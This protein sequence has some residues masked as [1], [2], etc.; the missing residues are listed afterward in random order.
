M[1]RGVLLAAAGAVL[2]AGTVFAW[3]AVRQEREFRRLI[4]AGD[5]ALVRDQTFEAIE[6]FSGALA[7]KRDSM[8]GHLKRGDSYRRRGELGAA[9]RDLRDASSLDPTATRPLEL[10][11]DVN[12]AMGRYER[13]AEAYRQYVALDDRAPRLLYK[14]ALA[15]YRN[16]RSA[17]AIESLRRAVALD[18]RF[19]EAHYLLALC[20]RDR[21]LVAD[22]AQS[23]TRALEINPAFGAAREE[24]AD[25][26]LAQGRTREGIEQ[27]EALAAL[28][29]AR[30]QRMVNVGLAYARSG[31]T[32]AAITTLG[33]AAER[34][35]EADAVYIALGRVWLD[36]AA[37]HDD[38]VALS[39]SL[40]ALQPVASRATASS[41]TLTLYG[42]ALFLSGKIDEAERTLAQATS[43]LPA[44][45]IGFFYLSGAA[46]RRGH[47]TEA[48]DA[49]VKYAS[50]IDDDNQRRL[51]SGQIAGLSLRM[52]D[53]AAAVVWA[54]RAIDRE[55]PDP[56]LFG[57][58]A[59]AQF[60]LGQIDAARTTVAE[61]L[62]RDP[63][64]RTLLQLRRK[65]G[66]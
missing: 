42:R 32:D 5:A 36:A 27:L 13:A 30:P 16:G 47:L 20:L 21:K 29:P 26:D 62:A 53:P 1:K 38:R 55:H 39:K 34:Y 31:R 61:G 58:L 41:D 4:A 18:D 9:L 57:V 46:E 45:P 48:R 60:R 66:T 37:A 17:P 12:V 6:D 40:E 3:N 23:L 51:H 43:V 28:E 19:V 52:N 54:Q 22:A 24:L 35:P 65:I 7:L 64:N 2:L 14:L 44:E 25:L 15:Y 50:L 59:D 63:K 10:L 8:L 11:G 56:P 49:L 33:R